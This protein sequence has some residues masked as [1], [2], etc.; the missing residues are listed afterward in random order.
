[1]KYSQFI[2]HISRIKSEEVSA[3]K[4][5]GIIREHYD[6]E[7]DDSLIES[8][9]DLASSKVFTID[10]AVHDIRALSTSVINGKI[11]YILDDG[12]SI[13]VYEETQLKL[14]TLLGDKY[15]LIEYMQESADNFM[16]V[17]KA[18]D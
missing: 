11:D 5:A 16:H 18:L 8:Y 7:V 2:E 3:S 10:P 1:M 9:T 13:A 6:I 17:L 12:S 4:I 15:E 14:N